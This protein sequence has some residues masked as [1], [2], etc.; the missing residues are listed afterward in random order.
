MTTLSRSPKLTKGAIVGFDMFNPVASVIIFQYNPSR[1]SRQV[2]A[3][4]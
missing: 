4:R 1:L 2:Q 3:R